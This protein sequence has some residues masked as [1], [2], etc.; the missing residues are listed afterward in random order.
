MNNRLLNHFDYY[1]DYM[2]DS[3]DKI[4]AYSEEQLKDFCGHLTDLWHLIV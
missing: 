1:F 4:Q 2:I 3:V